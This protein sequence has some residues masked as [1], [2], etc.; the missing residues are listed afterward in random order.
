MMNPFEF[1][2]PGRFIVIGKDGDAFV[3]L[4]GATGRSPSSLARRFVQNGDAIFMGGVDATVKEGNIALLE[5]PAVRLFLN[6]VVVANGTQIE[7]ITNLQSR[8]ARQQ[9]SYALNE[10]SYEPDEYLTPRITGCLVESE[11]KMDGALHIVR[12]ATDGT[13][14]ASWSLSLE[15]GKGAFVSTYIGADVKPTPSF[16]GEPVAVPLNFGSAK[17]AAETV[18]NSF[19]PPKG[20]MDY[21]VGVIAVYKKI[22]EKPEISIVNRI[23]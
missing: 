15:S 5:Y 7:H 11:G 17:V 4:Y 12:H 21:R 13:D 10:E 16:S 9:L 2:Y 6:G 8:D 18:F 14:R 1:R 23:A 22:G 19:T 20:E 3:V